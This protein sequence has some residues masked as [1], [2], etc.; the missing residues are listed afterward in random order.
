MCSTRVAS[1][2]VSNPSSLLLLPLPLVLLEFDPLRRAL[3]LSRLRLSSLLSG[4]ARCGPVRP[5]ARSLPSRP[6]V[7]CARMPSIRVRYVTFP[8]VPLC[9]VVTRFLIR[10]FRPLSASTSAAACRLVFSGVSRL[11]SSR[12]AHLRAACAPRLWT[13]H[14]HSTQPHVHM[15]HALFPSP[16]LCSQASPTPTPTPTLPL[17]LSFHPIALCTAFDFH[18][19]RPLLTR[20]RRGRCRV[21]DGLLSSPLP[22]SSSRTV[23]HTRRE[24]ETRRDEDS[25]IR[26][27]ASSRRVAS[28]CSSPLLS[29]SHLISRFSFCIRIS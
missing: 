18:A 22:V 6:R 5:E 26:R 28:S 13:L 24:D 29:T 21:R 25:R 15:P 4:A 1:R 20:C 23:Q 8:S 19:A 17:A 14:P 16:L 27:T 7:L 2:R 9:R 12:T 11:V 10:H 3:A